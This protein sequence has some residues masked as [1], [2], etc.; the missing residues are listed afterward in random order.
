MYFRTF[1]VSSTK[2][3]CCTCK[4]A[5]W[6]IRP[7]RVPFER[8]FR[9][10]I[11]V[12]WYWYFFHWKKETGLR[13]TIYKIPVNFSLSLDM[14]PGTDNPNQWYRKLFVVVSVR[15]RKRCYLERYY[16]FFLENFHQD[17]PFHLTSSRNFLVF[18]IIV[19]LSYCCFFHR[20]PALPSPLT[21]FYVLFEQTI[22]II[23][24][25]AFS[26]G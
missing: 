12:K 10:K 25:F 4:V 9:S 17:E 16:F 26:L 5:F 11:S 21:R 20:C 6:L 24:S 19:K 15:T 23:D 22:N 14:K 8:T 13:C 18:Q 3:V 2:E 7:K 1:H